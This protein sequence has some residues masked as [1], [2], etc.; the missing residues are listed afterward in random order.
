MAQV[1][2]LYIA[3]RA[4]SPMLERQQI[5]LQAGKGIVGDRYYSGTGTFS[6]KLA[7][8][9]DKEI[10][11]IATEQVEAFN[12][13]QGHAFTPAEFRRNIITAGIDLN[14]LEGRIFTVGDV[15]LEGMRLCEPCAH[16]ASL[17][18]K[19]L[20]PAMVNKCGLRARIVTEGTINTNDCI[21]Q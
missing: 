6:E 3:E 12:K 19:D 15:K 10:T 7:G 11:L 13:E 20:L 14:T 16:L 17:L 9:P 4:G 18:S 5:E 1:I 8:L 2:A 21:Q